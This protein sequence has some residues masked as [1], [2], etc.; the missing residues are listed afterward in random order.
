METRGRVALAIVIF[1][2]LRIALGVP[3]KR[4]SRAT[5][6][7]AYNHLV[8][9][10]LAGTEALQNVMVSMCIYKRVHGVQMNASILA[11]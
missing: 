1:F 8:Q 11:L 2:L 6:A 9:S 10:L 3:L 4:S 7:N 5:P